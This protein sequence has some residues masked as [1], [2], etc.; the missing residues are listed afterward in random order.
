MN[1]YL[2]LQ[3]RADIAKLI[4]PDTPAAYLMN[5]AADVYSVEIRVGVPWMSQKDRDRVEA[6][7][8]RIEGGA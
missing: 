8:K 5:K 6:E 1:R 4:W 2:T 3:D 7:I